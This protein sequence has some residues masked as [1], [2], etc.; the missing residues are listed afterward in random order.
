MN[1]KESKNVEADQQDASVL[2]ANLIYDKVKF[3][4]DFGFTEDYKQKEAYE[5]NCFFNFYW[6]T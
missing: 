5:K 1:V 3:T 2:V 6:S 4:Y